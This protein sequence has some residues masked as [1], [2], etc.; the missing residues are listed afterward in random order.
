MLLRVD[1]AN[2]SNRKI[3]DNSFDERQGN[4]MINTSDMKES[5]LRESVI[6]K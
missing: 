1:D 4:E 6:L 5:L 3:V 2:K